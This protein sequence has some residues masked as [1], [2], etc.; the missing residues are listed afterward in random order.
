MTESEAIKF[1]EEQ[2]QIFGG[3]MNDFLVVAITALEEVQ[4]YREIGTAEE[5]REAV[6]KKE[7]KKVCGIHKSESPEDIEN[8]GEN[9]LFGY[10]PTCNALQNILWN[11]SNCG[12]C[13]QALDWSVEE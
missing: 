3:A 12:D 8:Y 4:Q 9:N 11:S 5:C 1:A 2:R 10:C 13:G 6:V 7:A